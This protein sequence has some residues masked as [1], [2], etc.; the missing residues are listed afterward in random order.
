VVDD[1]SSI[2]TTISL[3]LEAEGYIVDAVETGKEAIEKAQS[4]YYN[5]ALLDYRLPD[6][7]GTVLL[8][9]FKETTPKMVKIMITGYP[10]TS[11]AIESLNKHADAFLVK[12]V[13]PGVLI[14]TVKSEL[15]KQEEAQ[16]YSEMKVAEFIQTRIK[17]IEQ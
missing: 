5:L 1:D 2:R 8:G 15:K 17:Q 4:N 14:Q 10:S 13:D 6:M 9:T 12:P 11:N 16:A 3:I 7:E